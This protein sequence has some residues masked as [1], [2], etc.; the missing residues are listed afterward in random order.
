MKQRTHRLK[1]SALRGS[2]RRWP[3]GLR[4][5]GRRVLAVVRASP[6][7]AP[8]GGLDPAELLKPLGDS[9]PS[10]SGDYTGRRYSALT[11]VNQSNVKHLS[12]AFTA[13]LTGGPTGSGTGP[14]APPTIIGGEGSGDVTVGGADADQG[15]DAVGQRRALRDRARQRLGARR[16]RRPR[17]LALLLEDERRHAH[18]QPRRGDVGQLPLLR[19]ARTTTSSRSTR[20]RARSAGTRRSRRSASSTS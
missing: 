7:R 16:A 18:R 8:Q 3:Q 2:C 5:A 10:Y 9:W 14:G 11:Q 17:D 15:R 13:T 6:R 20:G 1:P 4:Y 19:H 12:L